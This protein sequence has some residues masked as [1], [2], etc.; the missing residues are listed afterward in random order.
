MKS[1]EKISSLL[2]VNWN[3]R[4]KWRPVIFQLKKNKLKNIL[5]LLFCKLALN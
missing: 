1:S 5:D 2:E 3:T 4:F